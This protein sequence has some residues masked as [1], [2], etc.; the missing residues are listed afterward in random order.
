MFGSDGATASDPIDCTACA[1]KRSSCQC[2]PPSV[3]LAMPPEA[4]PA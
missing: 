3:V 4:L 1:S 2:T